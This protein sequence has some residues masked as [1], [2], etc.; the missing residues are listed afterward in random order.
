MSEAADAAAFAVAVEREAIARLVEALI[1]PSCDRCVDGTGKPA[2]FC[3]A[4]A[5]HD[6]RELA[7]TIRARE[8]G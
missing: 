7:A 8:T 6:L 2:R 1:A 4:Y 3:S 5:C